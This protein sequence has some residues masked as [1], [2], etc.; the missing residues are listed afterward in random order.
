MF[1]FSASSL[2]VRSQSDHH[3]CHEPR[4]GQNQVIFKHLHFFIIIPF[5]RNSDEIGFYGIPLDLI[6]RLLIVPTR[7]YSL[8]EMSMVNFIFS[9]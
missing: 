6:D 7:L 4:Q 8:D 3:I 9:F 2:G 1:H 5:F